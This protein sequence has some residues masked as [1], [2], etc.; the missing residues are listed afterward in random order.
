MIEDVRK[1]VRNCI[2]LD[3]PARPERDTVRCPSDAYEPGS[4]GGLC[5]TD[6]H[7]ECKE[8]VHADPDVLRER[9]DEYR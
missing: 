3:A 5:E 8:C 7:Y 2:G 4:P 1:M 9:E 6:G